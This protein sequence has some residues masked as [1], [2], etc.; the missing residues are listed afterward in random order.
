MTASPVI[1][2]LEKADATL[3]TQ[4]AR[5]IATYSANSA[6]LRVIKTTR[7]SITQHIAA[8][9]AGDRAEYSR[10]IGDRPR[11]GDAPGGNTEKRPPGIQRTPSAPRWSYA[12]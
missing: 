5:M 10:R 3:R 11:Q 9:M 6:A 1:A 7:A 4:E 8:A 2:E 12:N